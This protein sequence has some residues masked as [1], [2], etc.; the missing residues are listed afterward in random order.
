[1]GIMALSR[2]VTSAERGDWL[3]DW[4]WCLV[5]TCGSVTS[6]AAGVNHVLVVKLQL[7]SNKESTCMNRPISILRR[8]R[9]RGYS[10][11]S[12]VTGTGSCC[13]CLI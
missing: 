1:M 11:I 8:E 5:W 12:A 10:Q 7:V 6:L 13:C 4:R 9:R 2:H 3:S